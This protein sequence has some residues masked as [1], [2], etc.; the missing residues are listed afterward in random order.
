MCSTEDDDGLEVDAA[1]PTGLHGDG[2]AADPAGDN[3]PEWSPDGRRIA[4]HSRRTGNLDIWVMNA[5]GSNPVR[6]TDDPEH[7]YLPSWSPDGKMITLT[8]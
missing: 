5:D 1:D 7:D 2:H 6:L 4:F 3:W 8:S